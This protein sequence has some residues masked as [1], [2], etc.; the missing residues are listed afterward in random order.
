MGEGKLRYDSLDKNLHSAGLVCFAPDPLPRNGPTSR[1]S[2][3]VVRTVLLLEKLD[4]NA[5]M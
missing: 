1:G 4:G 5:C 2:L 3:I